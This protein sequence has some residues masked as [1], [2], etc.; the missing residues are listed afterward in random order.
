MTTTIVDIAR[1]VGVS[2]PVVSK[3][4][5]GGK[6]NVGVS[7]ELRRKIES[8]AAE[9]G[10][11]PHAASRALRNKRFQ[12]IGVLMGGV[13]EKFFLPQATLSALTRTLAGQSYACSLLCAPELDPRKL[14]D[15]A[16]V[17]T[18]QVDSLIIS[19]VAEVPDSVLAEL[20][21][22]G[23]PIVWMNRRGCQN[24]VTMN[25]RQAAAMLVDHLADLGHER[26]MFVDYSTGLGGPHVQQRLEGFEDASHRRG[27]DPL[28]MASRRVPRSE[29]FEA[30][31]AWLSKPGRPGAVI[32]NS[33]SA[34][35]AILQTALHL[36]LDVPGD[37][38][39]ASFDDGTAYNVTIPTM[40]VAISPQDQLGATA[41]AMA[42]EL[43][44]NPGRRV[45]GRVLP[46]TLIPGGSTGRRNPS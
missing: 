26:V 19:Y 34:A 8:V 22:L 40:T 21:R 11:R 2:H 20:D 37:I 31:R 36:R 24:T 7:P 44:E 1:T 23:L 16:M 12:N 27:V 46:F 3:V 15:N 42:I 30:I 39:I 17:N 28:V 43:A 25:E 10:Y 33:M 4:L 29:R 6:S 9:L 45:D 14:L 32:A 18:H 41:A 38:A 35:Q 13:E 5:H